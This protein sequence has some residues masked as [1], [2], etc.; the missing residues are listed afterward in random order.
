MKKIYLTPQISFE[1]I[2]DDLMIN[3]SHTETRDYTN[4]PAG[5]TQDDITINPNP[6]D[7]PGTLPTDWE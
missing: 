1:Y 4:D 2:E 6:A 5:D 3:M 7:V